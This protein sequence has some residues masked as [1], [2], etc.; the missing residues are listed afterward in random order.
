MPNSLPLAQAYDALLFDLD[1]V[2]YVGPD[3][4]EHAADSIERARAE[5]GP[6]VAYIT[7]NAS[8][9]AESVA[10]QLRDTGLN[11]VAAEVVTSAQV[12]SAYLARELPAGSNVLIVGGDGLIGAIQ[13]AGLRPVA[14]AA[15]QPVAV[16][17]GFHPDVG[18]RMLAEAAGALH[19]GIPWVA[20]NLDLT[21]PTPMGAAPGNGSLVNALTTAT[22][23]VP[24]SV[25]KPQAPIIDEAIRRTGSTRPLVIG[26]RLDTDIAAGANTGHDTLLVLTGISTP[27]D[28]VAAIPGQRPTHVGRDLR[29][30]LAPSPEVIADSTRA[31][32]GGWTAEL[33]GTDITL[34][35][36]GPD[37]IA[38]IRAIAAL[39]WAITDTGSPAPSN[40]P[41]LAAQ[42]HS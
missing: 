37:P 15:D 10:A 16:V 22:G 20:T 28:L 1:G 2:I 25:G 30:L 42:L 40:A 9:T 32:C 29:A 5:F 24:V 38:G 35:T 26:D 31:A 13:D 18:W 39:A 27:A 8:R 6:D 12:A 19:T 11:A 14:T 7:N 23:R 34:T 33:T 17:Q 41:A 3:A 21:L 4:I 36:Q